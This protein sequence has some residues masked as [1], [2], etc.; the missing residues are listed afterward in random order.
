MNA[1]IARIISLK[2]VP[3]SRPKFRAEGKKEKDATRIRRP[4]GRR[5]GK[6]K[7]KIGFGQK[8]EGLLQADGTR[9]LP[10]SQKPPIGKVREKQGNWDLQRFVLR[11]GGV[12]GFD[13]REL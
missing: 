2:K 6:G 5:P 7:R 12:G 3:R 9:V 13:V 11:R 1:G 4:R 10:Q 8:L